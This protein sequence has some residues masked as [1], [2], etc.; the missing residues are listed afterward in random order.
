MRLL[1]LAA[2]CATPLCAQTT[3]QQL[4]QLPVQPRVTP[5]LVALPA[6][7]IDHLNLVTAQS[8]DQGQCSIPLV[9]VVRT[10]TNDK[11]AIPM[12]LPNNAF[13]M[14]LAKPPAPQCDPTK[15]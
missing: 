2:L 12:P 14:T 1:A 13:P 4:M 3:D 10:N 8:Q 5:Q 9:N 11:F 6:P 15:K 7:S